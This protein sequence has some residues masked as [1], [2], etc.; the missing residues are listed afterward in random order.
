MVKLFVTGDNHF[1]RKFD[2]YSIKSVLVESRFKSLD[3]MVQKAED[4]K[5]E[6]FIITGDLFDNAH[7]ITKRD[8]KRVVE[9]LSKFDHTVLVLPGNHDYYSGNEAVWE[10]FIAEASTYSNIIV[11]NEYKK[12]EFE[13]SQDS[14][15][16]YPAH[17]DSKHSDTNRIGWIKEEEI[18]Q[19]KFNIGIAHGA[20]EGLAIDTEGKYFPMTTTELHSIP[21][22]VWLLGHAHVTEPSIPANEEVTGYS[23][24]NAGTHEQLD[25]HNNTEGNSFV[26]TLNNKDGMKQVLAKRIVTGDIR[27]FDTEINISSESGKGL[28]DTIQDAIKDYPSRSIVRLTIVGSIDTEEYKIKESIYKD[29]LDRFLDYIIVDSNLSEK[30]T[31]EKIEE[32]FSEIG[33]AARFLEN[34][35][36]EP[37]ELQMAYDVVKSLR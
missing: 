5:C 7:S 6:F 20:L 36:E 18:D 25:L 12:Y 33:F 13:G 3:L 1:G 27:Y 17:C 10:S 35:I 32:E 2:K 15:V 16:V 31:K 23:I 14:I 34:L 9:I 29:N 22:D 21:V 30:I 24:F 19:A 28:E 4:E 26:I 11:L 37:V 8:I